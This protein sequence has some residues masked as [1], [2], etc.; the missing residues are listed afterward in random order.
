MGDVRK[1]GWAWGALLA[2]A[3]GLTF[4]APVSAPAQESAR[5]L[6]VDN[7]PDLTRWHYDPAD[8]TVPA[9]TTVVW[10]NRGNEDHTVT[11]DDKSFDSGLKKTGATFSRVF[12]QPGKYSYY[13]QPHPWMKGTVQVVAAAPTA[14]SASA[15]TPTTAAATA[16]T[17]AA[18]PDPTAPAPPAETA[19]AEGRDEGAD[20]TPE[21]TEA[22]TETGE[23]SDD[24]AAPASDRDGSGGS[25]AGTLAVVLLPTLG[26]LALGAKLRQAKS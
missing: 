3:A 2:I 13:C 19:P 11:A 26:A 12:S 4:G 14:T 20:G 18:P 5:V 16:T 15:P 21:S 25:L 8:I 22:S 24:A 9:G 1:R 7:E 23:G 10:F 6:M 17:A